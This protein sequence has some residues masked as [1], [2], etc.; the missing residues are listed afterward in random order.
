MNFIFDVLLYAGVLFLSGRS[1][2]EW[3]FW[4]IVLLLVVIVIKKKTE[5]ENNG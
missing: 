1:V 2:T 3:Q 5:G 4:G